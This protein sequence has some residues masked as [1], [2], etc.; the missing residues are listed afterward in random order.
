M[1]N[2]REAACGLALK[3][4]R[5]VQPV[6]TD[7]ACLASV[8]D[9]HDPIEWSNTIF[10]AEFTL[11]PCQLAEHLLRELLANRLLSSV[12]AARKPKGSK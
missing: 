6:A 5:V 1:A 10:P 8:L 4:N 9:E 11:K 2:Y 7:S 3:E 12:K